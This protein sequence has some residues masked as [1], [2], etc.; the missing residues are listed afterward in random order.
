MKLKREAV[1]RLLALIVDLSSIFS[2]NKSNPW[3]FHN[4]LWSQDAGKNASARTG[5]CLTAPH[6]LLSQMKKLGTKLFV[7][8]VHRCHTLALGFEPSFWPKIIN[9]SS[10]PMSSSSSSLF[11]TDILIRLRILECAV[12]IAKG[13]TSKLNRRLVDWRFHPVVIV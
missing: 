5:N 1:Q 6:I 9:H 12:F 2:L 8:F 11:T 7:H 4:S 10:Q 3:A 13:A